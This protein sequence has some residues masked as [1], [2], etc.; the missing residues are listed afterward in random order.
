MYATAFA[1]EE[2]EAEE[3]MDKAMIKANK[4]IFPPLI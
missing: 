4:L 3:N 2:E 1:A